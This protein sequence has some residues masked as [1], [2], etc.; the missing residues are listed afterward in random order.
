ME[1]AIVR[2]TEFNTGDGI[3]MALAV[4]A[5]KYG[6]WSG[7]HSIGTDYNAPKVGDFNKPGDIYKKSSFPLGLMINGNGNRFVDE[8]ADFGTTHMPNMVVKC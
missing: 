2:G 7:C 8:G 6:E 3:T 4:G 5:Q 1:K